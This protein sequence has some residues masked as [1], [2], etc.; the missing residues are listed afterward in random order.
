MTR[1][2]MERQMG[3][4]AVLRQEPLEQGGVELALSLPSYNKITRVSRGTNKAL[5]R[6][7]TDSEMSSTR[8]YKS[9]G[10]QPLEMQ[11]LRDRPQRLIM[12]LKVTKNLI[13]WTTKWIASLKQVRSELLQKIKMKPAHAQFFEI[14]EVPLITFDLHEI[15]SHI[16]PLSA[17]K[18]NL[19]IILN[20]DGASD[21]PQMF[22]QC[23]KPEIAS[24]G[25]KSKSQTHNLPHGLILIFPNLGIKRRVL[26]QGVDNC[27]Q[28]QAQI[29]K[30]RIV[31]SN[32]MGRLTII[33]LSQS[34]QERTS[35][36]INIDN[37]MNQMMVCKYITQQLGC[38]STHQCSFIFII[39]LQSQFIYTPLK[40]YQI[41][42]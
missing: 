26:Q 20:Q 12:R 3:Q 28:L 21:S 37:M 29:Q 34:A 7:R 30:Q 18:S 16:D 32:V 41:S 4:T 19:Q 17:S 25:T 42:L 40:L 13:K 31:R 24:L 36:L 10:K 6:E 27:Q 14:N 33:G 9:D 5:E 35:S 15:I 39:T 23:N 8:V 2:L 11:F 22:K 1:P 38:R